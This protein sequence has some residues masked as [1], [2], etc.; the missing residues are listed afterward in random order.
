MRKDIV[1]S[2]ADILEASSIPGISKKHFE[3]FR[4]CVEQDYMD[5][6]K[7]LAEEQSVSAKFSK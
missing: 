1:I 5:W 6:M 4:E 7:E 3:D 2:E